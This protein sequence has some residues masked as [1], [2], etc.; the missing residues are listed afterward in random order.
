MMQLWSPH[1]AHPA[2]PASMD[3]IE[4]FSVWQV[5]KP[6]PGGRRVMVQRDP[7]PEVLLSDP[8]VARAAL[9]LPPGE[10]KYRVRRGGLGFSR[11][12]CFEPG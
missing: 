2:G 7:P 12:T 9:R 3:V 8:A 4:Y 10:L 1:A 5:P 11:S 6:V